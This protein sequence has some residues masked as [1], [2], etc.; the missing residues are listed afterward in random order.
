[1]IATIQQYLTAFSV[2]KCVERP[3]PMGY[4]QSATYF[5]IHRHLI[6]EPD[7]GMSANSS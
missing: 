6:V 2:W 4:C 1:M 5:G 3:A 7:E